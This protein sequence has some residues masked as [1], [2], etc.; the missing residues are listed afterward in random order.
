MKRKMVERGRR[1]KKLKESQGRYGTRR[2]QPCT[3]T[4]NSNYRGPRKKSGCPSWKHHSGRYFLTPLRNPQ[5][6]NIRYQYD[7]KQL[8][9]KQIRQ[10]PATIPHDFETEY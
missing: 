2:Q 6:Q 1:K 10:T 5:E 9:T 7:H 8:C 4:Q 3:K